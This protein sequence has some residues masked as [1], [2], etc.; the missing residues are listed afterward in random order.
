MCVLRLPIPQPWGQV[1]DPARPAWNRFPAEQDCSF[2]SRPALHPDFFDPVKYIPLDGAANRYLSFGL[3][4]R[5]EYEYYD[6]WML[7]AGPQDH[8]GYV[9]SPRDATLRPTCGE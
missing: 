1:S 5:T 4:Y 8:N 3:E 7:G 9:M 6:N 2:L